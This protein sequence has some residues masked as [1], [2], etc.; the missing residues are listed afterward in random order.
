MEARFGQDLG[1]VQV[2]TGAEA[3]SA[4]A[5]LGAKA[6]AVGRDVIFGDGQ[7]TPDSAEGRTLIAHELAHVVQQ[8]N[9]APTV[10]PVIGSRNGHA[11]SEASA[12]AARVAAGGGAGAL[13]PSSTTSVQ[14]APEDAPVD[15]G[16]FLLAAARG[17]AW[18]ERRFAGWK[19]RYT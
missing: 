12:A 14:R 13:S 2:H 1:D 15:S 19:P 8:R 18:L 16:Q 17:M 7:Y 10:S 5:S 3:A 9:A 6:F 11:E 4:A